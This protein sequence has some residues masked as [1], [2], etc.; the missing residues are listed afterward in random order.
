MRRVK[1]RGTSLES[2]MEGILTS[3]NVSYEIQ[4]DLPGHPDFKINGKRVLIFCDSSF[5]HG[6][7]KDD[8]T[9]TSFRKNRKFW[10]DKI[11]RNKR[12]DSS[13]NKELRGDGWRILR[14]W[15]TTILKRPQAIA[16]RLREVV[17]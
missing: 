17:G 14:F 10:T 13:V 5:W 9:G 4:P 15:D 6:R 8:V 12:R 1:S 2:R 16:N 3:L 11:T 7:R